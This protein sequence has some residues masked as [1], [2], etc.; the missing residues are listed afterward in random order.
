MSGRH[1]LLSL[2]L[3]LFPL[4]A[5]L[6]SEPP[7]AVLAAGAIRAV[8]GSAAI[9]DRD[10]A[11]S[12]IRERGER[13]VIG[14]EVDG[15]TIRPR[16]R[17]EGGERIDDVLPWLLSA[18]AARFLVRPIQPEIFLAEIGACLREKGTS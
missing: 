11:G 18:G 7:H 15:E 17:G 6:A 12:L 8:L 10:L 1:H 3:L 13:L 14:L 4:C 9:A 2:A 16:G 5:A